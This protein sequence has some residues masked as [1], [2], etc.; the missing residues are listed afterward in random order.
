MN[1]KKRITDFDFERVEH[2]E[3]YLFGSSVFALDYNDIDLALVYDKPQ[4]KIKD[5]ITYR[6]KIE[7][8]ISE[9]LS[10]SCNTILISKEEE[11]E[12]NFL[13]NAK[14]VKI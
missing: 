5:V 11:I 9:K 2:V 14:N 8:E 13:S 7:K 10:C 1:A 6:R 4:I 3:L 12:M